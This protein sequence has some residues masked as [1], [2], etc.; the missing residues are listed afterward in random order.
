MLPAIVMA[1]VLTARP[2]SLAA[3]QRPGEDVLVARARE[4]VDRLSTGDVAPILPLLDERMRAVLDETALRGVFPS[5]ILQAGAFKG[6]TSSRVEVR[7]E[8]RTVF[9]TCA[10]ER[11]PLDVAVVF[12]ASGHIAGL[13]VRPITS[14]AAAAYSPAAY[15][16]PAAFRDETL[17]VD[18]GGWPLP[19]TL[20]LPLGDAPVAA[21][22]L[23]HGSG[24]ADRDGTLG[25]SRP[26]RDLAEGLASQGIAVLRYE[27]RTRTH[28]ARVAALQTLTSKEEV[29]DDAVAAVR[30]L[31]S[32]RRIRADRIFVLGHSFGGM[33]A[34]RIATSEPAVA[35]LI[36]M[37]G[38]VRPLE[39]AI[40]AQVSYLA[41]LD[42]TVTAAEQA[43]IAIALELIE[44]ARTIKPSDPPLTTAIVRAPAAYWL[45][46][47][48]YDPAALAATLRLPMLILQGERD[49]QVTM[50]DDFAA[51]RRTLGTRANVE[52]RSYPAL[53]HLMIAGTGP[54]QPAE[55]LTPGHV[56]P[57]VVRDIAAWI[58]AR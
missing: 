41:N 24:P 58:K 6:Q 34:P 57:E 28:A 35:G 13:T 3:G 21:L 40:L 16:N 39:Q 12:D 8:N 30:L 25:G 50:A 53:N 20:S 43:Q 17:T 18:A 27:K 54:S 15:V 19:A 1:L 23:V 29:V 7:G 45:D 44:R 38:N 49:Y 33:M 10:F 56:D 46:L 9:V 31:R 5:V 42:G 14:S 36:V 37:A 47:R 26:L 48:G 22:V 32:H 2:S 11:S 51:W 4:V 55:Y 52:F